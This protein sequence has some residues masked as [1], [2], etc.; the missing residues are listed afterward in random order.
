MADSK[1]RLL[2]VDGHALRVGD[3]EDHVERK[4]DVSS[5][6][7]QGIYIVAQKG[8]ECRPQTTGR[9]Y[10]KQPPFIVEST[11][12]EAQIES[13]LLPT[14]KDVPA[15]DE[16]IPQRVRGKDLRVRFEEGSPSVLAND[17]PPG[18]SFAAAPLLP[19]VIESSL[20]PEDNVI[21]EPTQFPLTDADDTEMPTLARSPLPKR[22]HLDDLEQSNV[23][24][25][26]LL[27]TKMTP[28]PQPKR[29]ELAD[30]ELAQSAN[31]S[32]PVV[33]D[34]PGTTQKDEPITRV[35]EG[36]ASPDLL[37]P[38]ET[39]SKRASPVA[40]R[41]LEER[42]APHLKDGAKPKEG[43]EPARLRLEDIKCCDDCRNY[44]RQTIAT[45]RS[46]DDI[47]PIMSRYSQHRH[48]KAETATPDGYWD[49]WSLPEESAPPSP[50]V[51]P[52]PPG[53]FRP[54]KL[55]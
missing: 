8:S 39:F 1:A 12:P 22:K 21:V 30:D 37:V 51:R 6:A 17:E 20:A 26:D 10:Q 18:Q 4:V 48:R 3:D 16:C 34:T 54:K 35:S 24:S 23:P 50:R 2:S 55:L 27:F 15:E 32:A 7:H 53:L 46:G 13:F 33:V 43:R 38:D 11:V 47:L 44:Y 14:S 52:A 49:I 36:L 45:L 42:P 9:L 40:M 19:E 28:P 25:P 31:R 29:L 5:S 41:T